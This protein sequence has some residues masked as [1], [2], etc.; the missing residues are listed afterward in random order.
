MFLDVVINSFFKL[1]LEVNTLVEFAFVL[2]LLVGGAIVY[3]QHGN[4]RGRVK[5]AE[6]A[7]EELK[8][9]V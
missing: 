7:I 9:R 5:Q 8:E 6:A 1:L 4:I 2:G 3:V